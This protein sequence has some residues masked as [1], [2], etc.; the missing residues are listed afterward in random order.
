MYFYSFSVAVGGVSSTT[1]AGESTGEIPPQEN[2]P[3]PGHN[4]GDSRKK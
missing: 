3:R 1:K 4:D 2:I